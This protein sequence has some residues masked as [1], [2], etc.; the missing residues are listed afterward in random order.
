MSELDSKYLSNF[1][2]WFLVT[3][4]LKQHGLKEVWD[5]WSKQAE[6]YNEAENE[7]IWNSTAGILDIN[8]LVWVLRRAGSSREFVAKWK[9]YNP[10]TRE[11][12]EMT[13]IDFT[14]PFVSEGL[15]RETFENFET[16]IIK[17]CTGTGKTTA[18]ARH[19]ESHTLPD[20]KF[21]SITT[22]TTL[23]D[24][25]EKSF[26]GIRMKNY[27]DL[28]VSLYDADSLSI[29]LNSLMKLE[30]LGDDEIAKYII[31]IDEVASF[32]EFTNNDLL[33]NVL[34]RVVSTLT[35]LIKHAR[36]V[37]VSDA[38]I[39]DSTFELLKHRPLSRAVFLTNGFKKYEGVPAIRLRSEEEFLNTLVGHC[40]CNRPFLFGADSCTVA[41]AFYHHC[42]DSTPKELHD[43]FLL[44]TAETNYRVRDASKDFEGKY[45]FYSPKITFGVDFSSDVAQDMFIHM[46]GNSISPAGCFQQTTR[47]R[48]IRT[49][50][51][52]G[53]CSEDLSCYGSLEEVRADV[54]HAV[55]TS[56][57]FNT[58]CTYLDEFDQIQ[59]VKN[60]FFNLYCL[61]EFALD[62]YSS[63]RVRHYELILE[64]NG[65]KISQEGEKA[66][67]NASAMMEEIN[68][69]IFEKF[70]ESEDRMTNAKFNQLVRNIGYLK[71]D[72]FDREALAKHKEVIINKRR[73]EEHDATI[74]FLKADEVIN[75]KISDLS[76]K[77]LDLKAMT[78]SYQMIKL[79]RA[80]GAQWGFN[81]LDDAKGEFHKLDEPLYKLTRHVFKIRR[82]NP[83]TQEEAGKL[84]ATMVNK[85]SFRNCL[86]SLKSGFAWDLET[87]KKHIDLN[88]SK[89]PRVLGFAPEVVAKFGLTPN[90]I[91]RDLDLGLDDGL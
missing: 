6:N 66:L 46:T 77:C 44:V 33:D 16:I 82:A 75:D 11:A 76:L 25:H 21:L 14:A 31:Y 74:R 45:V 41:T 79:V 78:N 90:P 51:Y 55:A 87:I 30:A 67:L 56:Q 65:F 53:E 91:P 35:R 80:A 57:T 47:C 28:K 39:N 5:T 62:V 3:G 43:R 89:N 69:T 48:N 32:T 23:A 64:Q 49:L 15:S 29:C 86:K 61:N 88:S 60:T 2:D 4:I 36:K 7:Q 59:V 12:N 27:Q 19:M 50:Y 38:L 10:I 58:T 22:R 52:F 13:K 68:E 17:S 37:I 84:F 73:V 81:L 85:V 72:P 20:T 83:A 40:N 54:E 9:P 70:V 1:S 8:Y 24:Q 71:L 34:K 18:I 63:N 26:A 42:L